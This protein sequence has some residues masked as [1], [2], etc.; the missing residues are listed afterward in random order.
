[1]AV[2][3]IYGD[4]APR[5]VNADPQG[6]NLWLNSA[7]LRSATGWEL[8][9][10]GVCKGD[11]CV[12]I[13]PTRSVEF[14][15]DGG[16]SFNLAAFGRLMGQPVLHDDKNAVWMFGESAESRDNTLASLEAPDFGLPDLDGRM[17]RLSDYRGKKVLL[18]AWASW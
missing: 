11:V 5:S 8:K 3:L 10:E 7:D 12:P 16:N 1:M 13:P 9:P 14:V 6:D 4:L 18:A 15:R 17:H 2:T